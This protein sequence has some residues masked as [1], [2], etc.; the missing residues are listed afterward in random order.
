MPNWLVNMDAMNN[1]YLYNWIR[2]CFMFE[3]G[4]GLFTKG[5]ISS[6]S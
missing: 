3:L 2:V 1:M 4:L 6:I 5:K